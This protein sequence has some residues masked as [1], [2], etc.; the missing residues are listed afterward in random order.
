MMYDGIVLVSS[1]EQ[2]NMGLQTRPILLLLPLAPLRLL[3]FHLVLPLLLLLHRQ[4]PTLP[5]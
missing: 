5:L 4:L 2:A 3:L 1:E